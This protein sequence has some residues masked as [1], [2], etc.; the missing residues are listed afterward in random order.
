[1]V[2]RR[3]TGQ[4]LSPLS[5]GVPFLTKQQGAERVKGLY[6]FRSVLDHGARITLGSDFPIEGVNPLAGFYAAITRLSAEGTSP[7]GPDGW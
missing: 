4:S 1:M 2:C 3:A 6:K 5:G 7:H